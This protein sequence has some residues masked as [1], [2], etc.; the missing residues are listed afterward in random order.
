[1]TR[2]VTMKRQAEFDEIARQHDRYADPLSAAGK[3]RNRKLLALAEFKVGEHV[4][5]KGELVYVADVSNF[6]PE[7]LYNLHPI[8][9]GVVNRKTRI[10]LVKEEEL[11]RVSAR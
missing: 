6:G 10:W 11:E 2:L 3:E 4:R 1:M 9:K 7:L 8:S 5:Y